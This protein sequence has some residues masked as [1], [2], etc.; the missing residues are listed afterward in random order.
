MSWAFVETCQSYLDAATRSTPERL[1]RLTL[2][3]RQLCMQRLPLDTVF[4]PVRAPLQHTE[5][6]QDLFTIPDDNV[7]FVDLLNGA[8]LSAGE[9]RALYYH[10]YLVSPAEGDDGGEDVAAAVSGVWS[11]G[12]SGGPGAGR[13]VVWM[14]TEAC[15]HACRALLHFQ[16]GPGAL[17]LREL[18]VAQPDLTSEDRLHETLLLSLATFADVR[19]VDVRVEEGATAASPSPVADF[20]LS[21]LG[22]LR[23]TGGREGAPLVRLPMEEMVTG[24]EVLGAIQRQ[25]DRLMHRQHRDLVAGRSADV[26]QST[27]AATGR[28]ARSR[29]AAGPRGSNDRATPASAAAAAPC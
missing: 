5:G 27:A 26:P 2:E 20:M 1:R 4:E 24:G 19:R 23:E 9:L 18:F 16:R 17:V 21:C 8:V 12:E 15:S 22:F 14:L 25:I 29:S 3:M 10:Q 11:S 28:P 7:F 6:P 13:S